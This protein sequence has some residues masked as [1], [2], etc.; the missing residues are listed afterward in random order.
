MKS[1]IIRSVVLSFCFASAG[2]LAQEQATEKVD[3]IVEDKDSE[4]P[5]SSNQETVKANKE[6][7][8]DAYAYVEEKARNYIS[9][10]RR[11][12]SS[13]NKQV[14]IHS[15]TAVIRLKPTEAGWAD[16]RVLAYTEAQ[17]KAREKLLKQLYTSVASETIRK[18]F[19]T[20]KLPQFT[21]SEIEN[22][23]KLEALLSKVVALADATI[24]SQLE[25]LGVNPSEY[26]AAPPSKRKNMMQKAI[27]QS[28]S[29]SSRGDITGSQ[30][31]KSFEKTDVNGNTAVTV[32]IATSNK[33]KNFLA[34]LRK[35]KGN[36]EPSPEKAKLSIEDYLEKHR[37][38]LMYQIGTKM[39]W[40]EKGYPVILSF[41]MSGNDCNISDYEECVDN[42]EFSYLDAELNAWAHIS[43]AYN[44]VGSVDSA[45][46]T[47]SDKSRTA[48]VTL[49]DDN[50]TETQ[51]QTVAKIIKE[52]SLTSRMASSVKGLTGVQ[53][54]TRWSAKHPVTDREVN[55]VV[56]VWHPLAEQATRAFKANKN[57]KKKVPGGKVSFDPKS[58][59]SIEAD[60]ED[61]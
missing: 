55:G 7:P 40:D 20:N 56:L 45:S 15:G 27:T 34:S 1:S 8:E 52:T 18:S 31:M 21:P 19:K 25:E 49:T 59:E 5:A 38:N 57:V 41:G 47:T 37:S 23:S 43:E 39:H 30:I 9:E 35:S 29:T 36:I 26:N 16:A 24:D 14:F 28:V 3:L 60:D 12:F 48:T 6:Q 51:E 11:K 58:G 10:K 4:Q 44:L 53:E 61:F 32:V 17:Q 13:Q 2:I 46:T 54:A 42:R 33:K 22:Q 50:T